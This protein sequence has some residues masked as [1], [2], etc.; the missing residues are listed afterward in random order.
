VGK[1][2]HH[3][4]YELTGDYN[5]EGLRVRL[6][7]VEAL[8]AVEERLTQRLQTQLSDVMDRYERALRAQGQLEAQVEL[9]KAQ[10]VLLVTTPPSGSEYK[11]V[12]YDPY[13]PAAAGPG[14]TGSS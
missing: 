5:E 1:I 12:V 10:P 11:P 6:R 7:Q 14:I 3:E 9:L 8:L 4:W 13:P 2:T